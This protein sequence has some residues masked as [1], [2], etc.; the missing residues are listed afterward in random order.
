L[1]LLLLLVAAVAV[2][3]RQVMEAQAV[4]LVAAAVFQQVRELLGRALLAVL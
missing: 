3:M 2:L 4:A 1:G